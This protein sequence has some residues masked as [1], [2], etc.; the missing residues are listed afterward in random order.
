MITPEWLSYKLD[1]MHVIDELECSI[2]EDM[3]R[4]ITKMGRVSDTTAWQ[5]EKLQQSGMLYDDI[6]KRVSSKTGKLEAEITD[7]FDDAKTEIF[8]YD[9]VL[10]KNV[11]IDSDKFRTFSPAM[12]E[13][14]TAALAKTCT[15]AVNLTKTMATTTQSS[16]IS[17]CDLASMQVSSGAFSYT[18]AIAN[19]VKK[20]SDT[21]GLVKYPSEKKDKTDVAVRRA[22][23]TSVN[24]TSGLVSKMQAK[25]L[26]YGLMEISAHAGAR[27]EH[28]QWQG[29][30]VSLSGDTMG[31]KYLTLDDIG[32][33]TVTGFQGVNCRHTW[34]IFFE[35][36]STPLY[37][38]ST[39]SE[40]NERSVLYDG[41]AYSEYEATQMQRKEEREIRATKRTLTGLNS[42]MNSAEGEELRQN[43]K[44]DFAVQSIRLK[45]H[46]QKLSD[47]CIQ[48]G[49]KPDKA[50]TQV[51][52]AF[53]SK[54][55]AIGGFNKSV[56]Q[57]AVQAF[58]RSKL[59]NYKNAVIPDRK[60]T[61]Y[62]LNLN[63]N[64]GKHKAIAFQKYLGYNINNA[65]ML[66][67]AVYNGIKLNPAKAKKK[68]EYGQQYEVRMKLKGVN[69]KRANVLSAWII[70]NESDIPRL[71]SLYVKE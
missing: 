9:P 13:I 29:R 25:T 45:K 12:T 41:T 22:V 67:E 56:A 71:T 66:I 30:I 16:F 23:L 5:A 46:E 34:W 7:F 58:E 20:V 31:G 17:A 57:K 43:L 32:Y 53:D 64:K 15:D 51:Y 49:L 70:E 68:T 54:G 21:G 10:L 27:L 52:A 63:H 44:T 42:A 24:Q 4:R 28:A 26:G 36:V 2:V 47:L 65:D 59:P 37:S 6:V 60:I 1:A 39:L 8:N 11:G 69:G 14:W 35:G 19:A 62:S 18:Q 38:K 40:I 33:G 48:T 50:R 3:A 55:R 61:G